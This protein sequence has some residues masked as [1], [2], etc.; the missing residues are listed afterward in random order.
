MTL[1]GAIILI[2][3]RYGLG[4]CCF[5]ICIIICTVTS[6]LSVAY[7]FWCGV[8]RDYIV[9]RRDYEVVETACNDAAAAAATVAAF[10][11]LAAADAALHVKATVDEMECK[12][13]KATAA[14]AEEWE[15]VDNPNIPKV[16]K[17]LR[18]SVKQLYSTI[19]D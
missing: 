3:Q 2:L 6:A 12:H 8:R 17:P 14:K 9:L 19:T 1:S 7:H 10:A 5:D 13:A 16:D 11:A 18:C 4:Q 15:F